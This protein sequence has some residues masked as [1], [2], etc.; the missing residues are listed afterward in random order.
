MLLPLIILIIIVPAL[1][2]YCYYYFYSMPKRRKINVKDRMRILTELYTLVVDIAK[3]NNIKTF[4]LF[5]SLLGQQRNNKLICYDFDV[6]M[7]IISTDFDK[8]YVALKEKV[9]TDKYTITIN[10]NF[11]FGTQLHVIDNK[12]AL[13][14]DIDLYKKQS[15]GSFKRKLN[16]FWFFVNKYLFNQ[17][18]KHDIPHD[19]LLPLRPVTFLGK[20]VY[21]PNNPSALLECEYGKNYLTPDHTCNKACT[22]CVKI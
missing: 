11:L 14:L 9:N 6:D 17:C 18:D 15:N 10:D 2:Y 16:Y 5:G 7:G 20:K 21:I 4:L 1:C 12:T 19:W 3:Q 8:L 13:N 22:K